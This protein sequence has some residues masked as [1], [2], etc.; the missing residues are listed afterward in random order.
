MEQLSNRFNRCSLRDDAEHVANLATD[1]GEEGVQ[2]LRSTVRGGPVIEA[3]EMAGLLCKLD[4]QAVQVFLPGRMKDFPRTSQDRVVR[5]I[6][7]SGAPARC[8]ILLELLDHLDPLIMPLAIDEIGVTADRGALGRLL[9]I[10]DGDLPSGAGTYLRVK[11]IEALGR[12]QA[13]ESV[14]TL[15]RIVQAKKMLGWQHPQE[16]RI[17]AMQAV[18]KLDPVWALTFLPKSGLDK[19]DLTL[20]PLDL[21]SNCKFVRQRRHTR[22]RLNRPVTAVSTNLKEACRLEIK[23]ASLTGG[24]ATISRHL[25]PGTQVQLKF[26]LG[27][28]NLQATALMR[29]YRAQDMAFEIVDMSLDER[30]RLRR[31]LSDSLFPASP[32]ADDRSPS[33]SE[34][35]VP[36]GAAS[37]R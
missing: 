33:S 18:E 35:A 2:Y 8:S 16:L 11:A 28:R 24:V 17:A 29:D 9:T 22:V 20:A 5:L 31:L 27:L 25:A 14:A 12:I 21:S 1:L 7:A 23:T 4:P 13:P 34:T 36:A 37:S 19:A 3:V 26:Q 32:A 10:V 30:S 15:K 6:S